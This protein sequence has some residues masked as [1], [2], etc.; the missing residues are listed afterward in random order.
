MIATLKRLF[1]PAPEAPKPEPARLTIKAQ[2]IERANRKE[3]V[4]QA[5]GRYQPPPGVVPP[6]KL[7]EAMAMDATPYDY[8]NQAYVNNYFPGYQYLAMLAQLP[9]YR[10]FAEVPAKD[11][12]RK[13]ITIKSSNN[14]DDQ[15]R[16]KRIA[17]INEALTRYR[18]RTLFR[19]AAE[20]DAFYGR[21]QIYIDVLKPG[22]GSAMDD[23]DELQTP[24]IIA[25]AK[26]K[27]DALKGFRLIEPVWTYPGAYNST[28]PLARDFYQPSLW[29]VMGKT[30]HASRLLSFV[31][32]PVPDL[33][34]AAYNFGGLSLTQMAQP[35]VQ[36]WL[37]T[38]DSVSDLVHSFSVS[39]IK[40]NMAGVLAGTDDA[41]FFNRVELFNKLRDNRGLMLMD[42]DTEEFFQFNTPLSGLDAL[43]AQAQEQMSSV[44]SIP[45]V[46][47]LGVT[48]SGLN[49]SSEGEIQ[50]YYD[51]IGSQQEALFRD[52]LTKIIQV[53]QLSEFGDIDPDITADF[54]SLY[55]L[56]E[57]EAATVRKTDA[58]RD[59]VLVA[60]GII[61]PDEARARIAAD[62]DSGYDALT[63]ELDDG[64][65]ADLEGRENDLTASAKVRDQ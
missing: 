8:V 24:L 12:V 29:Y 6:S 1:R 64:D 47:L 38:R 43:Q 41:Q 28:N 31:S 58:D 36:N 21:A 65:D 34:K 16:L 63:E 37:R 22:D 50:V 62:P 53:I 32:R 5:F 57:V 61:S 11:M 49:A 42:K 9:E 14:D 27:K 35:Y 25:K 45:L 40:T 18:V 3:A 55:G 20:L 44:S 13:W 17:K 23:P 60:S 26:I 15:D 52:P 10:K 19:R 2:A 46:K 39:G 56:D 59:S 51:W 30:V 54:E 4:V 48:P 7:E 33:L